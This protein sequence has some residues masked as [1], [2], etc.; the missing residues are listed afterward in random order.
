MRFKLAGLVSVLMCLFFL[1][2]CEQVVKESISPVQSTYPGYDQNPQKRLVILPFADYT[3]GARPDEFMRRQVKVL[4]AINHSLADYG[5]LTP[6]QED[7]VQF[8][9]D[10]GIIRIIEGQHDRYGQYMARE[11]GNGWSDEMRGE[12]ERLVAANEAI[13]KRNKMEIAKVGFEKET[14]KE[15]GN[16]FGANYILRGRIVEYEMRKEHTLNPFQRGILPFFFDTTSAT[17]FGV[18]KSEEYD[19]WQNMAVGGSLGALFGSEATH[20]FSPPDKVV[21]SGVHPAF[22][23]VVEQGGD[24]HYQGYNAAVWGTAGAAAAYLAKQGGA[25]PLAVVQVYLAAQE[26]S[27]GV[28]VWSNRAEVQV[29]SQSAWGDAQARNLMDRAVEEAAKTLVCDF[30]KYSHRL[31][32]QPATE[33][34][35]AVNYSVPAPVQ[36]APE[37]LQM[38][39]LDK[40]AELPPALRGS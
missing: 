32:W 4:G 1:G 20:P 29:A 37:R 34:N 14:L 6:V 31:N 9:A 38:P 22:M 19:L 11:M 2:A 23:T 39:K 7:V 36:Q 5:F 12:I 26:A 17:I 27:T 16:Y 25:R 18:A 35:Y 28:V 30:V 21:T 8:L 33:P 10:Q 3:R 13:S 24:A 40:P 15:L